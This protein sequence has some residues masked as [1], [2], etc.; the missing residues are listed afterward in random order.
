M[1]SDEGE[2][3][4]RSEVLCQELGVSPTY[5]VGGEVGA[6]VDGIEQPAQLLRRHREL[7]AGL[8]LPEG[9]VVIQEQCPQPLPARPELLEPQVAQRRQQGRQA[10][11][12]LLLV[13][14]RPAHLA[15]VA[16]GLGGQ[17]HAPLQEVLPGA[18][19][20]PRRRLLPPRL[21]GAGQQPPSA[22]A[23][24]RL[25]RATGIGAV[26]LPYPGSWR[27]GCTPI[28]LGT[29]ATLRHGRGHETHCQQAPR[30]KR[31]LRP[32]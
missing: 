10:R 8:E 24:L 16:A 28:W 31:R 9:A 29:S 2:P 17:L 18:V 4:Q 21:R 22:R 11:R 30:E 1:L 23:A 5:D 13:G 19:R 26:V 15:A 3:V 25:P 32:W 14:G 12:R 20:R 7:G 27:R 6:G